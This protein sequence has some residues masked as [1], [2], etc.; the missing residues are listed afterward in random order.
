MPH[1]DR[2]RFLQVSSTTLAASAV[3]GAGCARPDERAMS[4]AEDDTPSFTLLRQEQAARKGELF[5]PADFHRLPVE[6]HKA[7]ARA[8]KAKARERGVDGG[9]FLTNRWNVIYATGLWHSTTERLFTCFLPM[10]ED[11]GLVWFH[12]YI[13]EDL[14]STWWHTGKHHYFDYH[15]A[16]GG[17]PNLGKTDQGQTVDLPTWWG[18]TLAGLGYGGKTIGIDSGSN[19]E[20]GMLPGQETSGRYDLSGSYTTPAPFRP[21]G[22]MFGRMAAALPGSQ[23]VDVGDLLLRSR[24]VKDEMENRLAQR[25][26]DIWSEVH[27][28]ARHYMIE[29]GR[30]AW[31]QEVAEAA[32]TWGIHRIM[33]D[34]P[35]T[36]EPHVAVGITFGVSCRSG[37][38]TG[39][40][41]PNQ[42]SYSKLE[43]GH[44][45][46][47]SCWGGIGGYG[48]E[49]Y[50][51]YLLAPWTDW[52]E[53]VWEV[54]TRSYEIQ[55]EQSY[56]G[57]TC[58]NVAKAVHDWQIEND[59][60]HLVYHRPGHGS[61]SEG[62]Q[63]PYH[64]L[65]DYT[66]LQAGM[67]FSNEPGL[68]D[69]KNG[70]GFNHSNNI[71]VAEKKGLQLG[72]AP[73]TKEWC[74][75]KL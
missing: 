42:M 46:Q 25:A 65:G 15:H 8:L 32:R 5:Q 14:V 55:A 48:G 58:S 66:V 19:V 30:E 64:A 37:R 31:D 72:T 38:A 36:N 16:D 33:R 29:R 51:S 49:Q 11:E 57:N 54:H 17:F 23:F 4:R 53:K 28:F 10:D 61:G 39:Y 63:P 74:L 34:I 44:A 18:Q 69:V 56:V 62:H 47:V 52:Q 6:W 73:V 3:V 41:H 1:I 13:D 50:R 22:G 75:L 43:P 70:F 59:C 20:I 71:V 12:P 24:M 2:R 60:A 67:H 35:Q 40:P 68:Y 27:A 21:A 45:V 26:E 7:K 9:L